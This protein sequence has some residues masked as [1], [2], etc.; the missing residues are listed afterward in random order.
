ML[1]ENYH[2]WQS[3]EGGNARPRGVRKSGEG[4]RSRRRAVVGRARLKEQMP[5]VVG[6]EPGSPAL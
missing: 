1:T 2:H 5:P 3:G 6:I 4:A